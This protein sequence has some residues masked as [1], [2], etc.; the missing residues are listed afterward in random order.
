MRSSGFY[1]AL[2]LCDRHTYEA[3]GRNIE[4]LLAGADLSPRALVL[5]PPEVLAN[6]ERVVEALIALKPDTSAV[7]SVGGGT[8]HDIGRFIAHRT[9]RPFVSIPTAASV[10][11]FYSIGAPLILKGVKRTIICRPPVALFASTKVLSQ[12]PR[13]LTAAGFGDLLGKLTSWADWKLGA[14]LWGEPFDKEISDTLYATARG[15]L[16]LA[17]GIANPSQDDYEMLMRLLVD[18]GACMVDAGE[19]RPASGAEHH[20]SHFWE[21]SYLAAGRE[22]PLH[23]AKVGYATQ[24]VAAL[25]HHLRTLDPCGFDALA[26]SPEISRDETT[27]IYEGYEKPIADQ[28]VADQNAFLALGEKERLSLLNLLSGEWDRVL[29]IAL[30]VPPAKEIRSYLRDAGA[31]STA[32]E[33]GISPMAV[34][35]ALRYADYLRNRFTILKLYRLLGIDPEPVAREALGGSF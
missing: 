8:L 11:G 7:C 22:P 4:K 24:I 25:Y 10:D 1:N 20:L 3:Y 31:P 17:K 26:A 32:G 28:L 15:T 18:S 23:G 33:L 13:R 5:G 30:S 12:A 29:E 34:S 19:S 2:V 14:L 27:L 21:M 6:E 9:D 16:K 35:K